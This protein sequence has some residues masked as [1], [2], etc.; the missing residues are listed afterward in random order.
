MNKRYFTGVLK[1]NE[2]LW[3][4]VA[5]YLEEAYKLDYFH[6]SKH[7]RIATAHMA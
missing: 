2:D 3:L 5:N 6:L 4:E 1:D 7:V